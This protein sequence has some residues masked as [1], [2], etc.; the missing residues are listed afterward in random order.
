MKTGTKFRITSRTDGERVSRR[1]RRRRARRSTIGACTPNC[2]ALP[3]TDPHAR[4]TASE[5]SAMRPPKN[6]ST[7]IMA[8]FQTTGAV[9]ERKNLRWL[10]RMPRHHA[11]ITSRPAPG[12][13][14]RTMRMA[15]SRLAP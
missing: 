10:F 5:G 11:D 8:K 13:R 3:A 2:S 9:Y 7:P 1:T 14:T 12:N 4:V 6:T 15:S